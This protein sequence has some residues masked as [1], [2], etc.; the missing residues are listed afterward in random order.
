M[1]NE[2]LSDAIG[3]GK[4]VEKYNGLI[5]EMFELSQMFDVVVLS[6]D[7]LIE[8]H[9]IRRV[10]ECALSFRKLMR[11][12]YFDDTDENR[13][14]EFQYVCELIDEQIGNSAK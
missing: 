3:Q 2:M 4:F 5:R 11:A 1:S 8:S 14:H 9:H 13:R 6:D 7:Y 10:G 12:F